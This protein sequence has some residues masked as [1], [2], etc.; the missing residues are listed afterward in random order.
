MHK[1]LAL[2]VGLALVATPAWAVGDQP[3]STVKAQAAKAKGKRG[4]RGPRGKRGPRGLPGLDGPPGIDGAPGLDGPEGPPGPPGDSAGAGF[5]LVTTNAPEGNGW[6]AVTE[7]IGQ[8][9]AYQLVVHVLCQS[10]A[11]VVA[12]SAQS[13]VDAEPK[14]VTA[15]C[16]EGAAVVGGGYVVDD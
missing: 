1:L 11:N 3:G 14:D 10:G 15:P 2:I 13:G 8:P 12:A 5:S 7:N 16:P 9:N 6:H 4:P